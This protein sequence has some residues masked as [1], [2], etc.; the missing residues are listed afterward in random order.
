GAVFVVTHRR[1]DERAGVRID[2]ELDVEDEA[3]SVDDDGHLHPVADPLCP[4]EIG[5]KRAAHR[6]LVRASALAS[7][8]LTLAFDFE[9]SANKITAE[10]HK[11]VAFDVLAEVDERSL[12]ARPRIEHGL[13]VDVRDLVGRRRCRGLSLHD[14]LAM[15]MAEPILEGAER[16]GDGARKELELE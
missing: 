9:D 4:G 15:W 2:V 11:E 14:R 3:A 10:G 1:T 12:P 5:P 13:D 6:D 7:R 16:D 8:R